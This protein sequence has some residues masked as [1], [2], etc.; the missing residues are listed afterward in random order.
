MTCAGCDHCPFDGLQ[1]IDQLPHEIHLTVRHANVDQFQAACTSIGVKAVLIALEIR[2]EEFM[3]LMTS[4]TFYGTPEAALLEATRQVGE[5]H[6]LGFNV[7]REKIES[8]PWHPQAPTYA[9]AKRMPNGAY[10]ESH[11]AVRTPIFRIEQLRG[12][13]GLYSAHMSRN[14]FK[15]YSDYTVYMLTLRV[16]Q[17]TA[18]EF[19]AQRDLLVAGL[20]LAGFTLDKV[21]TE[22]AWYDS[23]QNH[24]A[25]WLQ[26]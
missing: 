9:N 1:P 3:D 13:A 17:G 5:L 23:K 20:Q 12:I 4:S 26:G 8:A 7:I 6:Q 15:I 19:N 11:I 18:E 14:A 2:Q 10:F 16:N 25:A 24:D 22:F 21:I